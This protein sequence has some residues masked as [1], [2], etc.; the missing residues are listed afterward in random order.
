[1]QTLRAFEAAARLES[2]FCPAAQELDVTHG[3][4]SHHIRKLEM[5]LGTTL[6]RRAGRSMIPTREKS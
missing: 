6:F 1:M 4:M 5:Q 3:A 2:L